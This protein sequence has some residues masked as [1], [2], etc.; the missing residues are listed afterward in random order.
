[1]RVDR[2]VTL[3]ITN[4]IDFTADL[5][6]H[7]LGSDRVFRYNTDLW[8][9]YSMCFKAS[10][11][12]VADPTGRNVTDSTIAK[13]FRRSSMRGSVLFPQT[14]TTDLERYAEEEVF[15]AWADLLNIFWN[16]GKIVLS[17]PLATLHSGKLQQLRMAPKYFE[18]APYSFVF[19]RGDLVNAAQC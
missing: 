17:Q 4:S 13:V 7:R 14:C 1:M 8:R 16:Q 3:V 6:V 11:V 18:I 12:E 15:M 19:N 2:P 5:L 9:D 10:G